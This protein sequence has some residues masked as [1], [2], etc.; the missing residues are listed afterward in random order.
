MVRIVGIILVVP[1][2]AA[3]VF[4]GVSYTTCPG[5]KQHATAR[6]A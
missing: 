2:I 3:F 1:G 5:S 6:V 4:Q